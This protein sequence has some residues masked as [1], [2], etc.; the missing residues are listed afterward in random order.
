VW[1]A[2]TLV[3][4]MLFGLLAPAIEVARARSWWR[5]QE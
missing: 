1:I 5:S 2:F 4:G 3:V